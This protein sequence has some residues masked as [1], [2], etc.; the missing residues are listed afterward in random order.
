MRDDFLIGLGLAGDIGTLV[1]VTHHAGSWCNGTF[2]AHHNHGGDVILTRSG[3]ATVGRYDYTAFG[4]LKYQT[5]PDVC[6]FKFS[7]KERDT[8]TGFSYH[9][10]RFYASQWQRVSEQGF[11]WRQRRNS[12]CSFAGN[13]L[14]SHTGTYRQ[15]IL[16]ISARGN[17][18]KQAGEPQCISVGG[19]WR[20]FEPVQCPRLG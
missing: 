10:Y 14:P 13:V 7:T 11:D 2:Y 16:G 5:G 20:R 8:S 18:C 19:K 17:S 9:G 4:S 12:R 3:T 1:A 6:R 15:K